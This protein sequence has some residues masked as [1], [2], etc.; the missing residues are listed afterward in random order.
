M[1]GS[2]NRTYDKAEIERRLVA[3]N[4]HWHFIDGALHRTYQTSDWRATLMVVNTIGHLAEAAWHHPELKISYNRI[5][6]A[7][8]THEAKG[9]TER[10]FVLA[11]EIEKV[12]M[13]Q[14]GE[15]AP[16]APAYVK[17]D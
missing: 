14:P 15:R 6:I 1:R 10:D 12:V 17:G 9:I 13:W 3:D 7:L 4:P 16:D 2:R 5:E 8:N 11:S